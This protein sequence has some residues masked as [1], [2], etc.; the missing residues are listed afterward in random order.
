M[1]TPTWRLVLRMW[2]IAAAVM[3]CLKVEASP[4][5]SAKAGARMSV[6]V[7][8]QLTVAMVVH[9]WPKKGDVGTRTLQP[10]EFFYWSFKTNWN[11][12]NLYWCRF[13][14]TAT[15]IEIWNQFEVWNGPGF[16][17]TRSM[18]CEQCLWVAKTD[19]FYRAEEP[20]INNLVYLKSWIHGE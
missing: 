16:F 12:S 1:A 6:R 18:A 9:C 19:G 2:I 5:G 20:G 15:P 10:G 14:Q 8:N 4:Y 3:F 11:G 13:E 7:L 17:G